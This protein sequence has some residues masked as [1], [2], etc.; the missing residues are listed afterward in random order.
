MLTAAVFLTSYVNNAILSHNSQF[1]KLQR[2]K[3][4]KK[5]KKENNNNNKKHL[6]L[7]PKE[8]ITFGVGYSRNVL[9][10]LT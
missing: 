4:K 7:C 2:D 9:F 6:T 8:S 1:S 5:K 3:C 10:G